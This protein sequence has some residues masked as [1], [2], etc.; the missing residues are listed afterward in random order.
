M[1]DDYTKLRNHL[2]PKF[3]DY[4]KAK[5]IPFYPPALSICP[6]CGEQCSVVLDE[7]WLCPHCGKGGDIVDY[8]MV[9]SHFQTEVPAIR[10]LC[11]FL[12]IKNPI[13]E[14]YSADE[15]M[16]EQFEDSIFIIDKLLTKGL[17]ILAGPSK[18]GKSWLTLW[19]A[20]QISQ[21]LPVWDFPTK[22]GDV[23]YF[24]LE[25]PPDRI[26]RRLVNVT[27]GSTGKIWFVTETELMGNGFEEQLTRFLTDH[28]TV[29]FVLIDTL[30]KIRP[31]T[32]QKSIYAE[33]YNVM[34]TLK[35]IAD[36]FEVAILLVHHVRKEQSS[37]PFN[38]V[39]G[40][41][42]LMGCADSTFVLLREERKNGCAT[43]DATGR[44]IE[45]LHF[46]LRFSRKDLRWE[47][48][49]TNMGEEVPLPH[50]RELLLIQRLA[51][52]S[53]EWK[54]TATELVSELQSLDKEFSVAPN[55]LVRILNAN[56]TMLKNFYKVSYAGKRIGNSKQI[57]L[58]PLYDM[59]D[60]SD[61]LSS[62][63][64]IEHIEQTE[65]EPENGI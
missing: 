40:S 18:S 47:L 12:Q 29:H 2:R 23:L 3:L 5:R 11:R 25:D 58:N 37:D 32:S 59:C 45:D 61:S 15:I 28:K 53:G 57:I 34:S 56:K 8:A 42:G 13:I 19:L 63:A 6:C 27:H 62:T 55:S 20:H 21:G 30:Q 65:Q 54:G 22:Q 51:E 35:A 60:E 36:R 24:S 4:L 52:A 16:D 44:D 14:V 38:M 49:G 10:Y 7:Q 41:T 33:D 46:D 1:G 26:Q 50:D 9:D 64:P 31:I 48:V 39:S 43:L 17:H